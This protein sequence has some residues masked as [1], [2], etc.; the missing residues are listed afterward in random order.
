MLGL[1][2]CSQAFSSCGER[3]L[4]SRAGSRFPIVVTSP[5]CR[6]QSLGTGASW[7]AVCRLSGCGLWV[8][9]HASFRSC[10]MHP[11]PFL[12]EL[13]DFNSCNFQVL[14]IFRIIVFC[15]ICGC[16]YFIPFYICLLI[17]MIGSLTEP[18]FLFLIKS[19]LWTFLLWC[20]R[21]QVLRILCLA[22]DTRYFLPCFFL[23][24][25]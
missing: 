13:S 22:P 25:L 24:V 14:Y 9:E 20:F 11:C 2:C 15:Q 16:K 10:C 5:H 23:K 3:G 7:V 21:W 12:M 8:L 17:P 1:L 4:L 6:G 19:N 18:K